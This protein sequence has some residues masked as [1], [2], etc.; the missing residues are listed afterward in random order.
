MEVDVSSTSAVAAPRPWVWP[1]AWVRIL[2][3]E[4]LLKLIG[5][6]DAADDGRRS[7]APWLADECA[8]ES[9]Y[10]AVPDEKE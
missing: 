4:W 10:V 9:L 6:P 7:I 1:P 8:L 2:R 3:G 5:P